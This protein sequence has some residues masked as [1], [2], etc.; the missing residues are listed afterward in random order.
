MRHRNRIRSLAQT[1]SITA[2]TLESTGESGLIPFG[3]NSALGNAGGTLGTVDE[4]SSTLG[5]EMFRVSMSWATTEPTIGVYSVAGANAVKM[6]NC[7]ARAQTDGIT[8]RMCNI[9]RN[10]TGGADASQQPTGYGDNNLI[11]GGAAEITAYATNAAYA[12]TQLGSSVT[13]YEILNEVEGTMTGANYKLLLDEVYPA[14]KAVNSSLIV[15]GGAT[16]GVTS[17]NNTWDEPGI[18][19]VM[20]AISIH[21]YAGS[22]GEPEVYIS[23]IEAGIGGVFSR[24]GVASFPYYLSESGWRA[25]LLGGGDADVLK[26]VSR[27]LFMLRA[28]P[29]LVGFTWYEQ[30]NVGAQEWGLMGP[31]FATCK[32]QGRAFKECADHTHWATSAKR[33]SDPT[34]ALNR[35]VVMSNGTTRRL[36]VWTTDTSNAVTIYVTAAGPGT[37]TIQT[38]TSSA[39]GSLATQALVTGNNPI[40]VTLA[41]TA[42]V[43]YADV[44]ITFAQCA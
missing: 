5:A 25:D 43:L 8:Y 11:N 42:Q 17:G 32:G 27:Y 30:Y 2:W 28:M 10:I 3:A 1:P 20:D 40:A 38:I 22:L 39:G 41:D 37:L 23:G 16:A 24:L 12:A 9:T 34:N 6:V 14:I 31:A 29:S 13:H 36:A 18:A 26:R 15:V 19:S 4:L 44:N 7:M 35:A 21:Q 33:Y